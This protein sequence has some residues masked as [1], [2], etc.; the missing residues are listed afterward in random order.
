M[1]TVKIF[2]QIFGNGMLTPLIFSIFLMLTPP[3][4]FDPK[5]SLVLLVYY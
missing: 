4:P 5:K 1:Q 3:Q 2:M